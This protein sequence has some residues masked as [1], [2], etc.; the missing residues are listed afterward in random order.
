[1]EGVNEAYELFSI[2]T[3][4]A[5]YWWCIGFML[6]IHAGFL[7]YETGVSRVKNVLAS[8]MKNLMTIAVVIPTFYFFGWWIYNAFPDGL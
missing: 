4:E 7:S 8:A 6:L 1:M 3:I 5:F 2:T